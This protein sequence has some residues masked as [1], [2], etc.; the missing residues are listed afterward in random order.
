MADMEKCYEDLIIINLYTCA[1]VF[2]RLLCE[3]KH[4]QKFLALDFNSY[5]KA[6]EGL[7]WRQKYNC[8]FAIKYKNVWNKQVSP[9]TYSYWLKKLI[10]SNQ[11]KYVVF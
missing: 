1:Q 9:V 4:V 11:S 6:A 10:K 5:L 2:G 8:N 7:L 3:T